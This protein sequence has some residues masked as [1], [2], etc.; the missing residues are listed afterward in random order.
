MDLKYVPF[1]QICFFKFL[2]ENDWKSEWNWLKMWMKGKGLFQ[3]TSEW[4][5]QP[6][7]LL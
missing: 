5:T 4:S 2:T 7:L 3:V 6:I 1:E